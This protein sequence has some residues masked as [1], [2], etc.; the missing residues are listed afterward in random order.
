[1]SVVHLHCNNIIRQKFKKLESIGL[2]NQKTLLFCRGVPLIQNQMMG[3]EERYILTEDKED[4]EV[5][6]KAPACF[7]KYDEIYNSDLVHKFENGQLALINQAKKLNR[8]HG[9]AAVW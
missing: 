8:F 9:N 6:G 2:E 1:M 4:I 7:Y 5:V 3:M